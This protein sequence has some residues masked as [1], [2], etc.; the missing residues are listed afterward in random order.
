M[1]GPR[2]ATVLRRWYERN[3][4]DLPWRRTSEPYA[5]WVSEI[6]LQQTRV[7]TVLPYYERFVSRFPDPQALARATEDEVLSAWS[8]LGYYSR[9]R[10][11]HRAAST[12]AAAGA[13][14]GDFASILALPGAGAYTAAA[15]ASIAFGEPHAA[16]DGNV[17]RVLARIANDPSDI[18]SARTKKRFQARAEALLDRR[19]PGVFNQAMMELGATVCLSRAPLC[20]LCPVRAFCEAEKQGTARQLPV[21]LRPAAVS[22]VAMTVAAVRRRGRLLLWK[23][24]PGGFMAG[25]WELPEARALPRLES[26]KEIG[27]FT[28]TIMNRRYRVRALAGRLAKAP[29]GF[30]WVAE[31]E[32]SALPVSTI[33]RK[34][35]ALS[36]TAPSKTGTQSST[37]NGRPA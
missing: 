3:R 11:L 35:L 17:L 13:F 20:P 31:A 14:P 36:P 28:H 23:R 29:P 2:F 37:E 22:E 16:V 5:I 21:K 30:Q 6:M 24:P 10:N 33:A 19:N 9:A 1:A 34:A 18:G 4:R 26:M 15:V 25:F 32:L 27:E 7:E 12:I 8:G